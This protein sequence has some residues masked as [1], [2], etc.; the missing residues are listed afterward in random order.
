MYYQDGHT[1]VIWWNL[2]GKYLMKSQ[3]ILGNFMKN[4]QNEYF[5]FFIREIEGMP[6]AMHILKISLNNVMHWRIAL[7]TLSKLFG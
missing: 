7:F 4:C 6:P 1:P 2:E 5:K 3:G